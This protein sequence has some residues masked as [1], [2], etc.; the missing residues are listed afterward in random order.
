VLDSKGFFWPSDTDSAPFAGRFA[1][2][3][4][5][6]KPHLWQKSNCGK[7][8]TPWFLCNCGWFVTLWPFCNCGRDVT[9]WPP[10]HAV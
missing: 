8:A 5:A 1:R 9:A 10:C 7:F 2:P 4:V 6:R 3:G